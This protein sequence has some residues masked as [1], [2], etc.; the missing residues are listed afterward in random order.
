MNFK[1][2][3]KQ[4]RKKHGWKKAEL[5]EKCGVS[6][7]TISN[8]E[9]GK[10]KPTIE[11]L[12]SLANALNV[13]TDTVLRNDSTEVQE[14][15]KVYKD[16]MPRICRMISN[17]D[18]YKTFPNMVWLRDSEMT[19]TLL[20]LYIIVSN[21]FMSKDDKV[22]KQ[23]LIKNSSKEQREKWVLHLDGNYMPNMKGPF[24]SYIDGKCE[25]DEVFS[26]IENSLFEEQDRLQRIYEEK[27]EAKLFHAY[28]N[29]KGSIGTLLEHD[30]FSENM[31]NQTLENLK[32]ISAE[33]SLETMEGK[34]LKMYCDETENAF[35]VRNDEKLSDLLNDLK[36]L[37]PY[38]W[39]KIP[40][41]KGIREAKL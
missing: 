37:E 7:D 1:K 27:S 34:I 30:K 3:L 36:N 23:Y 16:I 24:L 41:S 38:V 33:L 22:Y 18:S 35:I 8:W 28:R 20:S 10:A 5:A 21:K 26:K 40:V 14:K 39:N 31:L 12:I 11:E 25:I 29:I 2:N 4:M 6:K 13:T 17:Y 15:E 19:S 32:K 9:K